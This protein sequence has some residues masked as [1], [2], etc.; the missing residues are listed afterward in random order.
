M[1]TR[2]RPILKN[3][4]PAADLAPPAQRVDRHSE[5]VSGLGHGQQLF[6]VAL[7]ERD[8]VAEVLVLTVSSDGV[9]GLDGSTPIKR[10]PR[11]EWT[12]RHQSVGGEGCCIQVGAQAVTNDPAEYTRSDIRWVWCRIDPSYLIEMARRASGLT[13]AELARQAGTSQATVSAYER[14]LKTPSIKVAARLLASAGLGADSA[15]AG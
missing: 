12:P 14:G 8:L 2:W 10:G 3:S 4:G 15:V 13:Q 1:V 11:V 9:G 7:G 6:G 5:D